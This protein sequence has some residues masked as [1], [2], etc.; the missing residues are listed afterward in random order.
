M[1][2]NSVRSLSLQFPIKF[3]IML[4]FPFPIP[5]RC[6]PFSLYLL[7]VPFLL[8]LYFRSP[9]VK[10]PKPLFCFRISRF[11]PSSSTRLCLPISPFTQIPQKSQA[12]KVPVPRIPLIYWRNSSKTSPFPLLAARSQPNSR[13]YDTISRLPRP[14]LVPFSSLL[15]YGF[16]EA[17]LKVP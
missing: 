16:L 12:S 17:L 2:P 1:Y 11:P 15:A 8:L 4:P 7:P 3:P 5:I 9:P 14:H 13:N 10:T 6:L